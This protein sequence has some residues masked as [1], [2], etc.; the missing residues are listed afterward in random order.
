MLTLATILTAKEI[1]NKFK[2]PTFS[3]SYS[4]RTVWGRDILQHFV[5]ESLPL[6]YLC[7]YKTFYMHVQDILQGN[8]GDLQAYKEKEITRAIIWI[9]KY[10]NK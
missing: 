2:L 6:S 5:Q 4:K 3:K 8:K 9:N 7:M 1:H 10:V